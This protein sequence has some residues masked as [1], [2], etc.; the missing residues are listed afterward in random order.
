MH[1]STLQLSPGDQWTWD[2]N[3]CTAHLKE[4]CVTINI[5]TS[6][7]NQAFA[8]DK[9]LLRLF[10]CTILWT[11][12]TAFNLLALKLYNVLLPPNLYI[13]FGSNSVSFISHFSGV[14]CADLQISTCRKF[15]RNWI[16]K[17]HKRNLLFFQFLL[18]ISN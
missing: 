13:L 16:R 15:K 12:I 9:V 1:T 8:L 7:E 4:L 5:Q 11:K 17:R 14:L 3:P 10:H 2:S 18:L 6:S